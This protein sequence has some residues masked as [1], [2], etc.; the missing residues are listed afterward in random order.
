MKTYFKILFTLT[1]LI[2]ANVYSQK[3]IN[4]KVFE[5]N[6]EH[7][8]YGYFSKGE[9]GFRIIKFDKNY[10]KVKQIEINVGTIDNTY[11]DR[12]QASVISNGKELTGIFTQLVETVKSLERTPLY[13]PLIFM[14]M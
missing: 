12:T 14:I 1:I 2:S 6:N 7:L 11:F 9:Y 10:N 8:V 4:P 5:Y 13:L 3:I